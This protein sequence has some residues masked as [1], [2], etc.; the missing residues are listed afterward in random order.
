MVVRTAMMTSIIRHVVVLGAI[1][2]VGACGGGSA[3]SPRGAPSA[4][5][6]VPADSASLAR[7]ALDTVDRA[8]GFASEILRYELYGDSVRIVTMPDQR[9]NVIID[10]MA[11]IWL[12]RDARVLRV[13]FTDSA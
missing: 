3:E 12:R 2:A 4:S 10:G 1:C 11:V 9:R 5:A 13:T 8:S 7:A 6:P